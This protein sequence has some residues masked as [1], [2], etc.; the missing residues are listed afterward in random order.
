MCTLTFKKLAP[1]TVATRAMALAFD[2]VR[3]GVE[4]VDFCRA[5]LV[6][7][8]S[9]WLSSLPSTSTPLKDSAEVGRSVSEPLV[10]GIIFSGDMMDQRAPKEASTIG[11][12]KGRSAIL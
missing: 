7:L 4:S 1:V 12:A 8:F 3:A 5:I 2:N 11:D 10:G 6:L 9:S